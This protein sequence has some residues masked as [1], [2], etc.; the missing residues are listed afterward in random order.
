L[1]EERERQEHEQRARRIR[2]RMSSS[3]V[4]DSTGIDW[5][6]KDGGDE[7]KVGFQ[8]VKAE[9]D[10][11]RELLEAA[12]KAQLRHKFDH[13]GGDHHHGVGTALGSPD[14]QDY[15]IGGNRSMTTSPPPPS[16]SNAPNLT[17]PTHAAMASFVRH[18]TEHQHHSIPGGDVAGGNGDGNHI[19]HSLLA[20]PSSPIL[21]VPGSETSLTNPVGLHP[22]HGM[23]LLQL[24][25]AVNYVGIT[26]GNP[27]L[28]LVIDPYSLRVPA[29]APAGAIIGVSSSD[30]VEL[31]VRDCVYLEF[32]VSQPLA[33]NAT[34]FFTKLESIRPIVRFQL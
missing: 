34:H 27:P 19:Q 23:N 21:F 9:N 6:A 2:R 32:F 24:H 31:E 30:V 33:G 25:Q 22:N 16:S 8:N 29:P 7:K 17:I 4:E 13:I 28:D 26:L 12:A 11:K 18:M 1:V 3:S 10:D 20:R 14:A 5:H 15:V